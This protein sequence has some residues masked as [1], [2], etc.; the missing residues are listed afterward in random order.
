MKLVK[1]TRIPTRTKEVGRAA[2]IRSAIEGFLASDMK[3][4]KVELDEYEDYVK[5]HNSFRQVVKKYYKNLTMYVR[6]KEIFLVKK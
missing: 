6:N 5:Y 2:E 4:C 3:I 1:E